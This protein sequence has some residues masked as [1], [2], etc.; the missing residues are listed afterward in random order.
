MCSIKKGALKK[1]AKLTKKDLCGG[2]LFLM[3]LQV[4]GLQL[5]EKGDALWKYDIIVKRRAFAD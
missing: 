1:F 2:L 3:K 4:W 5:Y